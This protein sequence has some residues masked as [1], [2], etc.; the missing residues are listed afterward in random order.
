MNAIPFCPAGFE[1]Y[2]PLFEPVVIVLWNVLGV[3]LVYLYLMLTMGSP[4][5]PLT[6]ALPDEVAR[7]ILAVGL[8]VVLSVSFVIV[9]GILLFI[10]AIY[11]L[12]LLHRR[13]RTVVA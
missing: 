8:V 6:L 10:T 2:A 5:P 12:S 9:I 7:G 11:L 3:P 4:S 1:Q 13:E